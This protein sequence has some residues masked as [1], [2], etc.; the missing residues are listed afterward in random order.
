M[1]QTVTQFARSVAEAHR[2][3][4]GFEA[5][6][7]IRGG[8]FE[9]EARVRA[10]RS[11]ETAL[12][13]RTYRS[14]ILGIEE[15]LAGGAEYTEDEL[16]GMTMIFTGSETW[17]DDSKTDVC[18][19]KPYR[20]L[21]EPLVGFDA[22]AEVGFLETLI[23][24]FLIR[25][26]GE[27]EIQGKPARTLR[28]RPKRP[29]R[30]HLLAVS[31][32]PIRQAEA[33]FDAETLFPLRI[34]FTPS[35]GSPLARLLQ[36]G[37]AITIEYSSLRLETPATETFA[38]Q[39]RDGARVFD[40]SPVSIG[41]LEESAPFALSVAPLLRRGYRPITER[42]TVTS[43]QERQRGYCTVAL[44]LD[45][46]EDGRP[47][48]TTVR[49]GN[50][51]S[52]NMSRRR[53][54]LSENGE[55]VPL[56]ELEAKILD[57]RAAWGDRYPQLDAPSLLEILWETDGVFWFLLGEGIDR[58]ELLDLASELSVGDRGADPEAAAQ[59]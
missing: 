29:Y 32:F 37:E 21:F 23:R 17:I 57:R 13:Y 53:A 43:D 31:S 26:L 28:L 3:L 34:R 16:I 30:S 55:A 24:D 11:G 50:Y 45:E 40:E 27:E 52:R 38:F 36:D 46:I 1:S 2:S 58:S 10:R 39:P 54:A 42:M 44:A 47:A 4:S 9:I 20:E 8:G 22:I 33:A 49:A 48:A 25:D 14:P 56:G 6:E 35:T 59:E 7:T 18:L 19:R 5:T 41:Q 51:L 15:E 12:E